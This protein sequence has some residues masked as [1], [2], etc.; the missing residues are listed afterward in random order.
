MVGAGVSRRA[1]TSG[2]ALA[3]TLLG[4]AVSCA[5]RQGE[6]TSAQSNGE[7]SVFIGDLAVAEG[8]SVV[9]E[10]RVCNHAKPMNQ[11]CRSKLVGT[12]EVV[13]IEE[14]PK[15]RYALVRMYPAAA[16]RRGDWAER[17]TPPVM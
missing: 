11:Q 2:F 17:E 7:A 12:G 15:G 14:T 10:R 1:I 6:V 9:V 16:V 13:R 4:L 8:E 5:P 3:T